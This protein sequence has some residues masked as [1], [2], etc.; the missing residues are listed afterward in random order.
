MAE[1]LLSMR[2]V[3]GSVSGSFSRLGSGWNPRLESPCQS[4][5]RARWTN[6]LCMFKFWALRKES[7]L[8]FHFI[9]SFHFTVREKDMAWIFCTRQPSIWTPLCLLICLN[10]VKDSWKEQLAA[11]VFCQGICCSDVLHDDC[12]VK[13]EGCNLLLQVLYKLH[14]SLCRIF[15]IGLCLICIHGPLVDAEPCHLLLFMD[16]FLRFRVFL[17]NAQMQYSTVKLAIVSPSSAVL[18]CLPRY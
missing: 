10:D 1:H 12:A 2:K 4:W 18:L 8:P 6:G 7:E 13:K 14:I 3:L 17:K 16:I 15:S 11:F 9:I 5:Y